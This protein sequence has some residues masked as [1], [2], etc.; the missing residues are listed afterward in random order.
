MRRLMK[1]FSLVFIL[2]SVILVGLVFPLFNHDRLTAP[3]PLSLNF[4]FTL[5]P[6]I[7]F[8]ILGAI[9]I[10]EQVEDKSNAYTFLRT[11]PIKSSDIVMAK[12]L[13]VLLTALF[14]VGF[15]CVAL[16][17]ISTDPSYLNPSCAFLI[18]NANLCLLSAGLVY[19]SIFHFGFRKIGKF[20]LIFWVL[21]IFSP[22][23]VTIFILP[24]WGISR[25]AI[26]EKVASLNWMS[27]TFISVG[28]YF[29]LMGVAIRTLEGAKR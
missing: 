26:I 2:Y 3:D 20:I 1:K 8:L 14:W 19:I 12:F 21:S 16:A 10:Q 13:L 28:I 4:V 7:F 11:L 18:V 9:Y 25:Q 17:R 22:I 23:P 15:H 29:L 5:A 24:Q 27:V 6:Y